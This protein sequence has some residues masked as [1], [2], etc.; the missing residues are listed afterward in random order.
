MKVIVTLS[1][2]ISQV[3]EF[4]RLKILITEDIY[5]SVQQLSKVVKF[6]INV[7]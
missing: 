6:N 3:R 2:H 5:N 1:K 4:G 7:S